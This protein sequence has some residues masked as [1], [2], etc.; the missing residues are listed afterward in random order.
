MSLQGKYAICVGA[1]SGIGRGIAIKLAEM[2]ANVTVVGRNAALGEEV[3]QELLKA[4]PTGDHSIITTDASSMKSIVKGCDE[5]LTKNAGKPLHYCVQTQGMATLAGR[6]ETSEG[7]DQKLALHYYGRI[8]FLR[9][10]SDRLKETALRSEDNDVRAISILSGG[11]HNS[12]YHNLDDLD[13]K[14]NFTLVN[15]ANA[16]GFYND[17]AADQ[18]SRD[19]D[20]L[21]AARSDP[22]RGISFIHAA[23][24]FVQSTWGKDFPWYLQGA[25]RFVQRWGKSTETCATLMIDN[26][27]VDPIR[28]G[29]GYLI[30]SE[31][32]AVA[33]VTDLHTDLY[34]EAVWKHTN[35]LIDRAINQ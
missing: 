13:L 12:S 8:L 16:A 27:L 23:P 10:L 22:T 5:Y 14:K 26:G 9:Q 34:R 30:M 24:G 11:V 29:Q 18:L 33:K 7:I 2:Q 31:M 1:T 20:F 21:K 17:L 3:L 4:N 35:E 6:T 15:A 28:R 25:L 32:G 19:S